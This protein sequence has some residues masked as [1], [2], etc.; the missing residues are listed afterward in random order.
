MPQPIWFWCWNELFCECDSWKKVQKVPIKS[1]QEH[2][3]PYHKK[4]K[5]SNFVTSVFTLYQPCS[6][7]KKLE[8]QDY[9]WVILFNMFDKIPMWT[10]WNVI[11]STNLSQKQTVCYM[12]P[13]QLPLTRTIVVK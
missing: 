3:E 11:N 9:I 4:L 7:Y 10:G 13:I 1:K 6:N 8:I 2:L 5:L 12:K